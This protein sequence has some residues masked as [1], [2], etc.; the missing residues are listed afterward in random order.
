M[1]LRYNNLI[2]GGIY[3]LLTSSFGNFHYEIQCLDLLCG[4]S[5]VYCSILDSVGSD[6]K[7]NQQHPWI[8]VGLLF[9]AADA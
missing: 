2:V 1:D 9:R 6:C 3:T 8:S 5:V 7:Q 4:G